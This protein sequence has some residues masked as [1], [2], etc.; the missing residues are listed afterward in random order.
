MGFLFFA[1]VF[2]VLRRKTTVNSRGDYEQPFKVTLN[3]KNKK[4]GKYGG[5]KSY[6]FLKDEKI[7]SNKSFLGAKR[8]CRSSIT[9]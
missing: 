3:K 7:F 2:E 5:S 8:G 9:K 4:D 6:L 1:F